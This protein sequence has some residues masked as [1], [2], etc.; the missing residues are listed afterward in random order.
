M[1]S[2]TL[3]AV[4]A[5][6][7]EGGGLVYAPAWQVVEHITAGRLKVVLRE[8]ELPPIPDQRNRH[9]HKIAVSEVSTAP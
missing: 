5:A 8:Y 3:D 4:V 7:L 1:R 2:N 6:A 9:P